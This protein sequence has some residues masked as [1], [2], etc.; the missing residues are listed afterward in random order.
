MKEF[1]KVYFEIINNTISIY[2][3][4]INNIPKCLYESIKLMKKKMLFMK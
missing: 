1:E 4:Y 2:D 3:N